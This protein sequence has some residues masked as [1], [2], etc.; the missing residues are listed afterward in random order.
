MT[1]LQADR[2]VKPL[3]AN[4]QKQIADKIEAKNQRRQSAR[5]RRRKRKRPVKKA[6]MRRKTKAI[7]RLSRKQEINKGCYPHLLSLRNGIKIEY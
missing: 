2:K 5:P 6:E 7:L 1:L 4:L 3:P